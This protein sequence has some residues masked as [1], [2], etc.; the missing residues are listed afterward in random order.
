MEGLADPIAST[1]LAESIVVSIEQPIEVDERTIDIGASAGVSLMN[2]SAWKT[3][4]P[5]EQADLALYRAKAEGK[6]RVRLFTQDMSQ[7]AKSRIFMSSGIRRAW[8][9]GEFELYYQPQVRLADGV[10]VGAQALIRWNHPER[11]LLAPGSFLST[12]ENSLLAVPAS[13]WIL[14]T[15]CEQAAK[16]RLSVFED[17]RIGV[18][19]FAA[20][21]RA[22]DLS[23][24]VE[25]VLAETSLSPTALEL[26]ITENIILRNELRINAM[27]GELREQGVGIAFDDYGTG[28]A[29]LTMLKDFPVTRLKIDRSFVSG[30]D[31]GDQNRLIVE[32]I[33]QLARG[34]KL[35][36]IAEGIETAFQA[37]LMRL[38]CG[39]GQGYFFGKPMPASEFEMNFSNFPAGDIRTVA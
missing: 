24:V 32:A 38:Y 3:D 11:G 4:L 8:E 21:F 22:G 33:S 35:D 14:R 39:E 10:V 15:A 34:L 12:L 23:S 19:L 13:E 29:S 2:A 28:F 31:A 26:E 25:G 36:V 37:D 5:L 16:W 9:H 18:N 1:T 30:P 6:D 20:Q 27:L 7:L 17:F